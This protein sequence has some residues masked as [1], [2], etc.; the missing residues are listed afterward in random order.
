MAGIAASIIGGYLFDKIFANGGSVPGKG[1]KLI[2][3]HGGEIILTK[4]QQKAITGAKTAKAAGNAL[5]RVQQQKK[6][7][8]T[9]AQAK[10]AITQATKGMKKAKNKK[11]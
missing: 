7:K 11:R 1:P 2:V 6:K 5:K 4:P 10:R 9:K 3:A 8:P